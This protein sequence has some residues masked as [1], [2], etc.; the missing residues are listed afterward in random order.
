[1]QLEL[2]PKKATLKYEVTFDKYQEVDASSFEISFIAPKENDAAKFLDLILTKKPDFIT[3][4]SIKPKQ[5]K[6]LTQETN[7]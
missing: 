2:F 3:N 4:Y 6:F 1:M 5:V 7:Q